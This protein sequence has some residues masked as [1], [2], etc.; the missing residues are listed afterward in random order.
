MHKMGMRL[1]CISVTAQNIVILIQNVIIYIIFIFFLS[2]FRIFLQCM[3]PNST[4]MTVAAIFKTRLLK[5]GRCKKN[6]NILTTELNLQVRLSMQSLH[7][8]WYKN[9]KKKKNEQNRG[10]R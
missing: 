2:E 4:V 3:V 6:S 7:F 1:I 5:N 10:I 8:L 9:L